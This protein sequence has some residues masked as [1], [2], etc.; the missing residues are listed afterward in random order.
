MKKWYRIIAVYITVL[1]LVLSGCSLASEKEMNFSD[2]YSDEMFEHSKIHW[3]ANV[4]ETETALGFYLRTSPDGT[5]ERPGNLTDAQ[6]SLFGEKKVNFCGLECNSGY[7]F[8]NGRLWSVS[9]SS[10]K[11]ENGNK[12]FDELLAGAR[13]AFGDEAEKTADDSG[14]TYK[15]TSVKAN[16]EETN[17]MLSANMKNGNVS[18]I[19]FTV[20]KFK[21]EY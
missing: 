21:N 14:S 17:A 5:G 1:C 3:G 18:S 13:E 10:N 19:N 16:G 9:I 7:Q 4:E 12:K 11:V 20:N 8:K 2:F 6:K 15:W